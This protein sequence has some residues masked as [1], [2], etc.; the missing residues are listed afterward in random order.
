M[1]P[2]SGARAQ[3]A[4]EG[5]RLAEPLSPT[6]RTRRLPGRQ[7]D[8]LE[9]VEPAKRFLKP[10]TWRESPSP[11]AA[12][13]SIIPIARMVRLLLPQ[14]QH[15]P[16]SGPRTILQ[17]CRWSAA[18]L[19]VRE[20]A[21]PLTATLS[22]TVACPAWIPQS[23]ARCEFRRSVIPTRPLPLYLRLRPRRYAGVSHVRSCTGGRI[24]GGLRPGSRPSSRERRFHPD[25]Q[26]PL[27]PSP[28]SSTTSSSVRTPARSASIR[29]PGGPSR[30][31][32]G[33]APS[34]RRAPRRPPS[35][36]GRPGAV[37]G[38]EGLPPAGDLRTCRAW[39]WA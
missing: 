25:A 7:V 31:R 3:D 36:G 29:G 22:V 19:A 4:S 23:G 1:R 9:H 14:E 26:S 2:A 20:A 30:P 37:A 18:S 33:A 8:S 39:A 24:V 6:S 28:P 38:P 16:R 21:A 32:T 17:G 13:A 10:S 15:P 27:A 5:R 11:M 12:M 34:H 35:R